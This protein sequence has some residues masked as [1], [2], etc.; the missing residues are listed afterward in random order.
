MAVELW[1]KV[2]RSRVSSEELSW[3]AHN[4]GPQRYYLHTGCG[5]DSWR[6]QRLGLGSMGSLEFLQAR[7]ATMFL[8]RWGG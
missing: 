6:Y 7:D 1:T 4:L 5:G 2:T 3:L 8:L